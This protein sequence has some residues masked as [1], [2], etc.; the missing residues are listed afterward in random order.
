MTVALD[1]VEEALEFRLY[2]I[3]VLVRGQ[4]AF[5]RQPVFGEA[6]FTFDEWIVRF[7]SRLQRHG[8]GEPRLSATCYVR[9]A[10]FSLRRGTAA[11]RNN[12]GGRRLAIPKCRRK[13]ALSVAHGD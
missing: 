9:C 6:H 4:H 1:I 5:L 3:A 2:R 7:W 10:S 13:G 11:C 12:L 8:D